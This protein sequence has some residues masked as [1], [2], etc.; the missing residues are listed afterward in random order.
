MADIEESLK[1]S[2]VAVRD[3]ESII[4]L[5]TGKLKESEEKLS[6]YDELRKSEVDLRDQVSKLLYQKEMLQ[7]DLAEQKRAAEQEQELAVERAE[8]RVKM[9]MQEELS[10]MRDEKI[11]LEVQ[12]EL[13]QKKDNKSKA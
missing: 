2:E 11:R 6:G 13:L 3:K 5:L 9:K 7:R 10:K 8:A 12:L 4:Q 1:K